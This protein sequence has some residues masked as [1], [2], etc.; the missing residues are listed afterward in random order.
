M[1]NHGL[2]QRIK[3]VK[4]KQAAKTAATVVV[5]LMVLGMLLW[6]AVTLTSP[7]S[8]RKALAIVGLSVVLV[9]LG[10]TTEKWAKVLPGLLLLGMLNSVGS[11]Y[12]GYLPTNPS[13]R[14]SLFEATT[15]AIGLALSL[16]FSLGYF[17]RKHTRVDRTALILYVGCFVWA[18]ASRTLSAPL[19][20]GSAVLGLNWSIN[21]AHN[22]S[23]T[24]R[25]TG[26]KVPRPNM[27]N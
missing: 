6:S 17:G 27:E 11:I 3:W 26:R 15:S 10:F 5:W 2:D 4:A 7:V 1:S 21:K 25:F 22:K 24:S 12:T 9:I 20:I 16:F 13:V 18:V 8:T 19:N 14:M 23:V